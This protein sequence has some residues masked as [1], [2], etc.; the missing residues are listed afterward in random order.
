[1]SVGEFLLSLTLRVRYNNDLLAA[2]FILTG[3]LRLI[4]N[5]LMNQSI[6]SDCMC[7]R[8][9]LDTLPHLLHPC[10]FLVGPSH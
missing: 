1:M 2:S 4:F 9:P 7:L 3:A 6:D 10:I 5:I 8:L